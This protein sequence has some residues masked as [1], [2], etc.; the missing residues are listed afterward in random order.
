MTNQNMPDG[1]SV[2]DTVERVKEGGTD[3]CVGGGEI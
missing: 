1:S 3:N 2:N